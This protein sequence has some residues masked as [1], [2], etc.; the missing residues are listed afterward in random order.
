MARKSKTQPAAA[1]PEVELEQVDTGGMTINE[2]IVLTTFILTILAIVMV[3]FAN[4]S[5]TVQPGG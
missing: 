5:L 1:A 4:Q 2:G 3:Y